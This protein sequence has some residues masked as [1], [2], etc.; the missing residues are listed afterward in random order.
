MGTLIKFFLKVL[1]ALIITAFIFAFAFNRWIQ[2]D[3]SGSA[4]DL[5]STGKFVTVDNVRYHYLDEGSGN[6]TFLLLHAYGSSA[7]TWRFMIPDLIKKGRVVAPDFIGFGY[8]SKGKDINYRL[9]ARVGR[10]KNFLDAINVHDVIIIAQGYGTEVGMGFAQEYGDQVLGMVLISPTVL[11]NSSIP[12]AL[13]RVPEISRAA[14]KLAYSE[15]RLESKYKKGYADPT[16]ITPQDIVIYQTP[17]KMKGNEDALLQISYQ[18]DTKTFDHAVPRASTVV[19]WGDKD[20]IVRRADADRLAA[21]MFDARF[22]ALQN[23]GYLAQEEAPELVLEQL[24]LLLEQVKNL[25]T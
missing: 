6:T 14:L 2:A 20:K 13:L 4:E 11:A 8:S 16:L 1:A 15:K 17:Y 3:V 24:E 22:F 18:R 21:D 25:R 19:L 23:V 12:A 7:D 10:I 5:V 9:E